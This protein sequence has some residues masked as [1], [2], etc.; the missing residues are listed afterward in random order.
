MPLIA[1]RSTIVASTVLL[2]CAA[3][4][5]HGALAELP[6]V[7]SAPA[8]AARTDE[9]LTFVA[10]ELDIPDFAVDQAAPRCEVRTL[11]P[12]VATEKMLPSRFPDSAIVGW[13]VTARDGCTICLELED[14]RQRSRFMAARLAIKPNEVRRIFLDV[15]V[16]QLDGDPRL[17]VALYDGTTGR[18]ESIATCS[19]ANDS[20]PKA[21]SPV[22]AGWNNA[23]GTFAIAVRRKVI[24][25][26]AFSWAPKETQILAASQLFSFGLC[27]MRDLPKSV[28][29]YLERP[30]QEWPD[31]A[32]VLSMSCIPTD[33]TNR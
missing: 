23:I 15:S 11:T 9:K 10:T 32:L 3:P 12:T 5:M 6:P 33:A 22:Q 17:C 25:I 29:E 8:S 16:R 18:F 14:P 13:Q 7:T 21:L 31:P 1:L 24:T 26:A 20:T 19:T 30:V 2:G 27:T 4:S 28:T